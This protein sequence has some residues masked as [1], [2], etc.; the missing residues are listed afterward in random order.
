MGLRVEQRGQRPGQQW[1]ELRT[2]LSAEPWV[3]LSPERPLPL[4]MG[5]RTAPQPADNTAVMTHAS[6][7][8]DCHFPYRILQGMSR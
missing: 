7:P 1:A 8:L 6:I 3:G 5:P 2:E 4:N